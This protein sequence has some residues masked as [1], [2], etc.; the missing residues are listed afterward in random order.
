MNELHIDV[1]DE[2]WKSQ[3]SSLSSDANYCFSF[4]SGSLLG[5]MHWSKISCLYWLSVVKSCVHKYIIHIKVLNEEYWLFFFFITYCTWHIV[6][7]FYWKYES[8]IQLLEQKSLFITNNFLI[9]YTP[10]LYP[11]TVITK[12]SNTDDEITAKQIRENP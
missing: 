11:V 3:S 9:N 7:G 12:L 4:N 10:K 2:M 6:L 8:T 1:Y 5:F